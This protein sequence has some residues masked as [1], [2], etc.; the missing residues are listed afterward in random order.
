MSEYAASSDDENVFQ[1]IAVKIA[2]QCRRDAEFLRLMLY[3][4]LEG[5]APAKQFYE[6]QI[7]LISDFLTRYI[8]RR[9]LEKAFQNCD[10]AAAAEGFIGAQLHR[11]MTQILFGGSFINAAENEAIA[12]FTKLTLDGLRSGVYC[13]EKYTG[14]F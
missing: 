4:A 5:H 7:N 13:R 6:N 1:A 14:I 3:S 11:A 12:D 2:E 9:Q 10:A 8:K